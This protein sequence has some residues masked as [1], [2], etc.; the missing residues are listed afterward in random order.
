MAQILSRFWTEIR[1]AIGSV[2]T[3]VLPVN[4][5]RGI[6]RAVSIQKLDW[7]TVCL[8][9]NGIARPYAVVMYSARQA[10]NLAL[11]AQ[12]Y[13]LEVE[14]FYIAPDASGI[15]A[16]IDTKLE[17]LGDAFY[18][19]AFADGVEFVD[20]IAHDNT[21]QNAAMQVFLALDAPFSAGSLRCRF[22]VGE[23]F[24]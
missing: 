3:D 13:D 16:T 1:A 14:I 8:D 23:T 10:D 24:A 2:W 5:G 19:Y 15:A 9:A 18:N 22:Y 12:Q 20:V 7:Q 6:H 17:A 11:A 4:L 21:E